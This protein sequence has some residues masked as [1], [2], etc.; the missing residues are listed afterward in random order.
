MATIE[1]NGIRVEVPDIEVL[2]AFKMSLNTAKREG[3][4]RVAKQVQGYLDE[5][6]HAAHTQHVV[7]LT[8]K[9]ECFCY[10]EKVG[11]WTS[12]IEFTETSDLEQARAWA[13]TAANVY[14]AAYRESLSVDITQ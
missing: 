3:F 9:N 7:W 12:K 2:A 8:I 11:G 4:D 13:K 1:M 10:V 14:G 5:L 6:E